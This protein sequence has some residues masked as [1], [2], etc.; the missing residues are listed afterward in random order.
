[1][2]IWY[3]QS[4]HQP[5]SHLAIIGRLA[6]RKRM[7]LIVRENSRHMAILDLG[8]GEGEVVRTLRSDGFNIIGI[9][10]NLPAG[11][12]TSYLLRKSAYETGFED[13]TFD[14]VLCLE[15]IEHL[16]PK[17][18]LEISRIL[19]RGGKLF[20]T[21]PKRRWNWL[22]EFLSSIRLSDPL[23]TPHINLVDPQDIPL[24]LIRHK[25]FMLVEWWGIYLN[26][27]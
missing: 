20:V 8:C 5:V 23:V 24:E 3:K 16:D 10:P 25:S 19:K 7:N 9:D 12:E 17:V 14:C 15:T 6:N 2:L 1:M 18:Y 26:R 13:N 27:K 11:S 4:Q 21:T 22:I